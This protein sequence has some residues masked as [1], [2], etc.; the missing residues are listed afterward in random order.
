MR[1]VLEQQVFCAFKDIFVFLGRFTV[2]AVADFVD[3]A[4]KGGHNMEQVKD[5]G[6][7]REF[8]LTAFMYGFHMSMTTASIDF[9]CLADS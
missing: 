7:L 2:F 1:S 9:F 5:D 8:F 6:R 4:V 3:N